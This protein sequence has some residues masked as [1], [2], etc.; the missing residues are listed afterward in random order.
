[1][2]EANENEPDEADQPNP[3]PRYGPSPLRPA[4]R[5]S[6]EFGRML[7]RQTFYE[8]FSLLSPDRWEGTENG[9]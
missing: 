4:Y 2:A 3:P 1:M 6:W 8:E 7:S 5:A 9:K